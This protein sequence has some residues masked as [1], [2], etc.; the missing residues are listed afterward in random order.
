L[1][2]NS[3]VETLAA[4]VPGISRVKILVDGN[5]RKPSPATLI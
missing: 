3:L 5:T 2:L 4:N 1:T